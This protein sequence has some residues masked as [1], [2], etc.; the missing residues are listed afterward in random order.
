[1]ADWHLCTH[2]DHDFTSP[3]VTD[4]SNSRGESPIQ[5]IRALQGSEPSGIKRTE[6]P[7][8]EDGKWD[9]LGLDH[10]TYSLSLN[11]I[12]SKARRIRDG[13]PNAAN[14]SSCRPQEDCGLC[15]HWWAGQDPALPVGHRMQRRDMTRS[16][17]QGESA[18]RLGKAGC[19]E[20]SPHWVRMCGRW[21]GS[22]TPDLS[23]RLPAFPLLCHPR[24]WDAIL[25]KHS[26]GKGGD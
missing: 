16:Q 11:V 10:W 19:P 5:R 12:G 2:V 15:L 26:E 8:I 3:K 9:P 6:I 4:R 20:L 18:W 13:P 17:A 7:R 22:F 21:R 1:M 23:P 24:R 14:A 25:E